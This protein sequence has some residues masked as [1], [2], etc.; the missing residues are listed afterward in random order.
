MKKILLATIFSVFYLTSVS[1]E[2]GVNVGVSGQVGL[3]AASGQENVGGATDTASENKGSEH[4]E[5][6]WGSIF[7]EKTLGDR[8]AI[9]VDYVPS[10]LETETTES[11]KQSLKG[12]TVENKVQIDFEDMTTLYLVGKITDNF[13]L[14][15]GMVEVDVITNENLGTGSTYGN[16]SLDGT[17]LGFGYN[18]SFDNG[19]FVRA[20][21]NYMDFDS[22]KLTST[23][24][25]NTVAINQLHGVA[26]KLS[27]GKSF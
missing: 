9:G 1:A 12:G 27:V 24:N 2:I 3:F 15:A 19:M 8:L 16:T 23:A 18:N 26:A 21:T 25:S 17:V 11:V 7:V 4:G 20:E 14:R 5:A 22:A 6:G 13:Y 10:S